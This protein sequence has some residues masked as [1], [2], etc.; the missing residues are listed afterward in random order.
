MLVIHQFDRGD[1][2]THL[3]HRHLPL[4]RV[5]TD[6]ARQIPAR[7][8]G[9]DGTR[10]QV[11]PEAGPDLTMGA[12]VGAAVLILLTWNLPLNLTGPPTLEQKWQDVTRPW[13]AT[14]DR[15]EPRL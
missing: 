13:R 12:L 8:G 14:R 5:G 1:P 4:R 7:P 3:A 2:Q 10:I 11:S 15:P 6:R 9:L